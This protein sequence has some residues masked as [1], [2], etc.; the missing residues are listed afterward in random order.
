MEEVL[1][2]Q[3]RSSWTQLEVAY[4]LDSTL[5]AWLALDFFCAPFLGGPYLC[6]GRCSEGSVGS[7][8]CSGSFLKLT[9]RR[10][11]VCAQG[12]LSVDPL[13][14]QDCLCLVQ[15]LMKGG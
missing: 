3:G 7:R 15:A 2:V 8:V 10:N 12:V 13:L 1:V 5:E 6:S 14:R 4:L 11:R 9:T